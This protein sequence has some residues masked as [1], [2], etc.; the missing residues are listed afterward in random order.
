MATAATIRARIYEFLYSQ[1]PTA[2]P[3]SSLLAEALDTSE[4]GVDVTSG[5]DWTAGD[6]VEVVETGEQMRVISVTTDTLTVTRAYGTVAATAASDTGVIN[7]NPRFTQ[8]QLNSALRDTL[9]GFATQGVHGFNT[10]NITLAPSQFFYNLADTDIEEQYGVLSV[11]YVDDNSGQ[12]VALPFRWR[13]QLDT[14]DADWSTSVGITLISKGDRSSTAS[15]VYYT[16]AQSYNFD[17][18]LDTTIAKLSQEQEELLVLGAAVKL[19][20]MTILPA[21]HEPGARTNRTV[22]PGQTVR[23]GRWFQ[24]EYFVKVRAE[25]ARLAVLRQQLPG[26]VRGKR[27]RRFLA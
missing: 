9:N 3:F 10:G 26:T 4:T 18:D 12:P 20:G 25:A 5:D 2:R 1:Y 23:D 19:I 6:I 16:Y 11:Y 21:T 22:P 13:I 15:D 17:T 27:A 24:G 7:K 14:S 8:D